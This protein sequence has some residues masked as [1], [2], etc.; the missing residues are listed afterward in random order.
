M[1]SVLSRVI[2]TGAAISAAAGWIGAPANLLTPTDQ[3]QAA[4]IQ[5]RD[6][7]AWQPSPVPTQYQLPAAQT[8]APVTTIRETT[9]F[10]NAGSRPS[11]ESLGAQR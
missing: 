4:V 5:V 3:A 1:K 8:A 10:M 9:D 6:R 11:K 2:V 7:A